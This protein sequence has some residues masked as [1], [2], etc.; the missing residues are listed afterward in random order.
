MVSFCRWLAAE[1]LGDLSQPNL[2]L[3]FTATLLV[4]GLLIR[5]VTGA[6]LLGTCKA[7]ESR[8]WPGICFTAAASYLLG[9][10]NPNQARSLLVC[11]WS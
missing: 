6:L 9:L 11:R 10:P 4:A 2:W 1:A 3:A 8:L 7:S 5:K